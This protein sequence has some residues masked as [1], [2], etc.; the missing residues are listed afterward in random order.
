MKFAPRRQRA[1][2]RR[3]RPR[4]LYEVL[5]PIEDAEESPFE[6]HRD[7]PSEMQL[8]M[9]QHVRGEKKIERTIDLHLD[10]FYAAKCIMLFP[11]WRGELALDRQPET[12]I[13]A[14]MS[15]LK[16]KR[17]KKRWESLSLIPLMELLFLYPEIRARLPVREIEEVTKYRFNRNIQ[18][19]QFNSAAHEAIEN[20]MIN[21]LCRDELGLD[22]TFR[23]NLLQYIERMITTENWSVAGE[24]LRNF[25]L[26]FP[27]HKSELPLT[28]TVWEKFRNRLHHQK[29]DL[30][31]NTALAASLTILAAQRAE[32]GSDGLIHITPRQPKLKKL[33]PLPH[34]RRS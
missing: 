7:I 25:A 16:I 33:T 21:P 24:S 31:G 18:I 20:I 4:R 15:I 12:S 19:N 11:E 17:K 2:R 6:P 9:L 5:S 28:P 27:D 30:I 13:E 34:R 22:D 1:E 23:H 29:S 3:P 8:E 26:L 14:I 10:V 32:I